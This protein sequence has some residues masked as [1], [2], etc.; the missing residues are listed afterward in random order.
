MRTPRDIPLSDGQAKLA[1]SMTLRHPLK[2]APRRV[3]LSTHSRTTIFQMQNF[4]VQ[5]EGR[6]LDKFKTLLMSITLRHADQI[7]L[8]FSNKFL[9]ASF[10]TE[11]V[12]LAGEFFL[13]C[14]LELVPRSFY[15]LDRLPFFIS[16]AR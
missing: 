10:R 1:R 11:I 8:R 15:I 14:S 3:V 5:I 7:F 9:M 13:C 4:D 12:F 6:P 2:A 16:L